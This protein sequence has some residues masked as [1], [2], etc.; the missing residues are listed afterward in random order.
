MLIEDSI[1]REYF[2]RKV[3]REKVFMKEGSQEE[4][5]DC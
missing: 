5:S 2:Y 4:K 3:V 1:I